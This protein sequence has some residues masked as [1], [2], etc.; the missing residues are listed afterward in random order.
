M[1]DIIKSKNNS[2]TP[3][4]VMVT[5]VF[6]ILLGFFV[7]S[8]VANPKN[9]SSN[10]LSTETLPI[11][12]KEVEGII[13]V[14]KENSIDG[15]PNP[16]QIT[17]SAV[18]GIVD[19]LGS[20]YNSFLNPTEA[21]EY[22]ESRSPNIEGIGVT[23]KFENDNTV[24]ETALNNYPAQKAGVLNGDIIVEVNGESVEGLIPSVVASKIRGEA[25]SKV[26]IKIFRINSKDSYYSFEIVR[27]RIELDPIDFK[28]LGDGLYKINIYQFLDVTAESFNK[29]WDS[30]VNKI[31]SNGDL[32]SLIVDLRNN[33]GG[34]VYSVR[35]VLE[36]FLKNNNILMIEESK[37]TPRKEFLDLRKGAFEDIPVVVLMNEGSAS[38]SEIFAA[39][40][41][42][43][44]RG[45]IVGKKSV[46]KGVEQKVITLE[47]S[48]ILILV[49]QK[50]LTPLGRNITPEDSITPNFQVE[51][52][53][54]ELEKGVDSQ[55]E[56]AKLVIK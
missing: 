53:I 6:G 28:A 8:L 41:Q 34:Y 42:D 56:K 2:A 7:S 5:L 50:W 14:I 31:L 30:V 25:G 48:S 36:D 51:I 43:N 16:D 9:Q 49:F 10:S 52:S 3:F 46:G 32:K 15:L 27:Q 18:K 1:N 17:D 45:K 4:L 33:P 24:I 19:S 54:E 20:K 44:A 29:K 13:K 21:K 40:I 47:D 37:D 26:N 35:Y 12:L 39:A 55:L 23:L 38:A 11:N 22:L